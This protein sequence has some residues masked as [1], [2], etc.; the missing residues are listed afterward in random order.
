MPFVSVVGP[1][2]EWYTSKP[3]LGSAFT[4]VK[5]EKR[6]DEAGTPD[7]LGALQQPATGGANNPYHCIYDMLRGSF[8]FLHRCRVCIFH[9][10]DSC[11]PPVWTFTAKISYIDA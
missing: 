5:E 7:R 8:F 6:C 9:Q 10:F 1:L 2:A 11:L 3:L 4:E